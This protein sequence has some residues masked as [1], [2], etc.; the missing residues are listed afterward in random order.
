MAG[1]GGGGGNLFYRKGHLGCL[2]LVSLT[3]RVFRRCQGNHK[4]RGNQESGECQAQVLS[5][6]NSWFVGNARQAD[7]Q[8]HSKPCEQ[9]ARFPSLRPPGLQAPAFPPLCGHR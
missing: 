6:D 3:H 9:N 8:V 1:G 7:G 5:S 2:P 4:A